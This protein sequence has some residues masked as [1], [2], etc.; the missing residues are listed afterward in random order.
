MNTIV[1]TL[2]CLLAVSGLAVAVSGCTVKA[3]TKT[4]TDGVVN[5]LSST[6]GHPWY[7][8]DGLVKQ[9]L[10]VQAFVAMNFDNLRQDMARGDGEYLASFATLL[11][12]A[13]EREAAFSEFTQERYPVLFPEDR[14]R[15]EDMLVAL[16]QEMERKQ[17][18]ALGVT[19]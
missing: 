6:S 15:P 16:L 11:G 2:G 12:V 5:V 4:T 17:D 18:A 14:T 13:P 8:E 10:K 9:D 1:R 3:T 19:R 7:T